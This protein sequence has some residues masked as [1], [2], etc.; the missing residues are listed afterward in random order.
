MNFLKTFLTLR[1]FFSFCLCSQ[2]RWEQIRR[3]REA[4]RD[5]FLHQSFFFLFPSPV[6]FQ[7]VFSFLM[8]LSGSTFFF[9]CIQMMSC[10]YPDLFFLSFPLPSLF[11]P[12]PCL[13]HRCTTFKF[14]TASS[15]II[16]TTMSLQRTM[17]ARDVRKNSEPTN[18]SLNPSYASSSPSSSASPLS[19]SSSSNATA[20]S[21]LKEKE[22]DRH[23]LLKLCIDVADALTTK[24]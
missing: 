9:G 2:S 1:F 14:L 15:S 20:A 4:V 10:R 21:L 6:F 11:L 5:I 19:S 23:R 12:F 22:K 7:F 8:T 24:W 17:G 18:D 16:G 3:I 13:I